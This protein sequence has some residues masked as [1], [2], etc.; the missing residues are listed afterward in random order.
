MSYSS[1]PVLDAARHYDA[2]ADLNEAYN[3]AEFENAQ[4]FIA[5]AEKCDANLV[6]DWAGMVTDLEKT[7]RP[8]VAGSYVAKRYQTMGELMLEALDYPKGPDM[9]EA[10]QLLLNVAYGDPEIAKQQACA[11]ILRMADVWAANNTKEVFE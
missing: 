2:L 5:S 1:D 8:I 10:M 11:L 4:S 7:P 3:K 6:I 9:S